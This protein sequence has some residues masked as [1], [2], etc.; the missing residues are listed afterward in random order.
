MRSLFHHLTRVWCPCGART[1]AIRM[2]WGA[3]PCCRELARQEAERDERDEERKS[4]RFYTDE[5]RARI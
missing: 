3:C 5:E 2:K 4:L 1:L